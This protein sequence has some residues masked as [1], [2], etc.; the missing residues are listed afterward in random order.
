VGLRAGLNVLEK[1]ECMELYL[2]TIHIHF[3]YSVVLCCAEWLWYLLTW[4]LLNFLR[5]QTPLWTACFWGREGEFHVFLIGRV[6]WTTNSLYWCPGGFC[7]N[8]SAKSRC[9]VSCQYV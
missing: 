9:F 2:H 3:T 6:V 5:H 7:Y 4:I 1:R 8:R